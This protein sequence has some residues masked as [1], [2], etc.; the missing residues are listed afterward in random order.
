QENEID[1][2]IS[3]EEQIVAI[4]KKN[5]SISDDESDSEITLVFS[6]EQT[7]LDLF[8]KSNNSVDS[9]GNNNIREGVKDNIMDVDNINFETLYFNERD[10]YNHEEEYEG[11]TIE[12]PHTS[13]NI[14]DAINE[15]LEKWNLQTKVF[16]ITTDNG[17]NVKNCV[18]EK[19]EE[20]EWHSCAVHTL[21]LVVGNWKG[22][23]AN[24][25]QLKKI[26]ITTEEWDL[27][28]S[29]VDVLEQLAEATDYLGSSTYCTYK[30]NDDDVFANEDLEIQNDLNLSVNQ[31][32]NLL[33][34]VKTRLHKNLCK[35]WNFQ[36]SNTLLASLL[37]SR[38]KNLNNIPA[39]VQ[40]ETIALFILARKYLPIPV[41]FTASE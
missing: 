26:L 9:I 22:I 12:Y 6:S 32:D 2:K 39:Q 14:K 7:S 11:F 18:K 13:E 16:L 35:Y 29:L 1:G 20:I 24:S 17:S 10:F 28:G 8:V 41:A 21:Q 30:I 3:T 31:T 5:N 37:N 15:V 23:N 40:T 27:L 38:T 19:L 34:L 25:K 4:L 36:D 33:N